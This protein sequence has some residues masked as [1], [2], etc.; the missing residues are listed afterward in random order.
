MDCLLIH[1]YPPVILT[2]FINTK[3]CV[4]I[5][6]IPLGTIVSLPFGLM[7]ASGPNLP[8][9]IICECTLLIYNKFTSLGIVCLAKS[10][11]FF[12]N[13]A[14]YGAQ[15]NVTGLLTCR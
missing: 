1:L 12:I 3:A 9:S 8:A 2:M 14:M 10:N 15:A 13:L 4:R 11:L 7:N 6:E 5:M